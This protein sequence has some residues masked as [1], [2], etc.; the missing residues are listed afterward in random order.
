MS[1]RDNFNGD[2]D[3]CDDCLEGFNQSVAHY[4][5]E[6][7][8]KPNELLP[9]PEAQPIEIVKPN[10]ANVQRLVNGFVQVV[11]IVRAKPVYGPVTEVDLL[12]GIEAL[13]R[14]YYIQMVNERAELNPT[15]AV[16]NQVAILHMLEVLNEE[17]LH[18]NLPAPV[19]N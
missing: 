16:C 11:E 13:V 14:S 9:D 1:C 18:I 2:E 12:A 5:P 8:P 15:A 6:G 10:L 17:I 7:D 4:E 19:R 3:L